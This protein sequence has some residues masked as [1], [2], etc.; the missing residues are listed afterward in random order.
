MI[1]LRSAL[2]TVV[3]T[4]GCTAGVTVT[5]P[6]ASFLTNDSGIDANDFTIDVG[7]PPPVI[8]T[9][10]TPGGTVGR[11]CTTANDC[12]DGCFCDGPE[13]C[14]SGHCVSGTVPCTDTVDCTTDGCLEEADR[15]VHVPDHS[16]CTDHLA[17]NGY[18]L[19]DLHRGCTSV[20]PLVCNDES[21]CT[22]D[23]CDDTRGC[24]FTARDLDHDGFVAST[25][26]G[27]DCDDY[28]ADVLP[29]AIEICDN[30]RDDNCDG[31]RDF[32][33][34]M[35]VPTNDTCAE[36]TI[37]QLGPTGGT[38]SGSTTGL[39]HDYTTSCGGT[40]PDAVF[41][42]TLT[43]AHDVRVTATGPATIGL[44][45][46][47]YASCAGGADVRC[48][49]A[50]PAVVDARSLPAGSWALI[51]SPLRAAVFDLR[52]DLSAPTTAPAVDRCDASTVDVSAG[53]TFTG[54][55]SDTGDDYTLTCHAT[56]TTDAAYRFTIPAGDSRDVTIAT[57]TT[58]GSGATGRAFLALTTDCGMASGTI[59]CS[60]STD[61]ALTRRTLGPGTYYVLMEPADT[62]EVSWSTTV[63]FVDPP[64]ARSTADA[65]TTAQD[66]TPTASATTASASVA[67]G[68][69][70]YDSGTGCGSGS[71]TRDAYFHFALT[72]AHDV[73]VTTST[74]GTNA[75]SVG[76]SCGVHGAELRCAAS[77][78]MVTQTLHSLP[79]GDYWIA[80]ETSAASGTM[81]AS[82]T[83]GPPTAAPANDVCSG[84]T[85]LSVPNDVHP[86][87]TLV[88]FQDDLSG[89]A[90]AEAG[91][92]DAFYSFTLT[93]SM[94]V[95]I[96]VFPTM[97]SSNVWLTLRATCGAG[98]DLGCASGLGSTHLDVSALPVGTYTLFVEMRDAEA[99]D[100]RLQF[101]A[102]SP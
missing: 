67:I 101:A 68:T 74:P 17:C 77:G 23:S 27:T 99:S 46:R 70:E 59:R 80:V 2:L 73:T 16:M 38:F 12:Q 21:S 69:L 31:L 75:T 36:A 9:C 94:S 30:R 90:C 100:F 87:D 28:Q 3:V 57:T 15:C 51:V 22:L 88:G 98:T 24:V 52:I 61:V 96:G 49:D 45:L 47:R 4:C 64:A 33:D 54:R 63:T 71:S 56:P 78:S 76:T 43:E 92:L 97:T 84:A 48:V 8:D 65:C 85:P 91:L 82:L 39:A 14:V 93:T 81:M 66:I 13:T 53:G 1:R 26:G 7:P 62:N 79:I 18:E 32:A 60:P 83:L 95:S 20:P 25:C 58:S 72:A 40:G 55:F 50:A 37:L 35:C 11:A 41:R 34:P 6:D 86:H 44:A 10:V 102:F 19:C 89:G 5:H 29:G 42:F